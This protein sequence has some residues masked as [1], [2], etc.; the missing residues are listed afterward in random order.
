MTVQI[1]LWT[2]RVLT[3]GL[4]V[5]TIM[6]MLRTGYW[7]VRMSDF[8]R[9]QLASIAAGALVVLVALGASTGWRRES[10]IVGAVLLAVLVWQ[11][12]RIAPYTPV[13]P[14]S[15]PAAERTDLRLLISNLD[16]RNSARAE[17]A[18]MINRIE[19]DVLLLI[20]IEDDW[21]QALRDVRSQYAEHVEEIRGDGLGI[22]LWSKL[23]LAN[24]EV[25]FLVS[26]RRPSIVADISLEDGRTVRFVGI[27]PTPPGLPVDGDDDRYD[28]RIRDAELMKVGHETADDPDRSWIVAGDFNDVAWSHTTTLFGEVSGLLDPRIGRKLLNTYHSGYKLLRYPLDHIF[29]SPGFR[30]A[31]LERVKAPGSDHFAVLAELELRREEARARPENDG[32]VEE[33]SKELI[34]EGAEDADDRGE[35]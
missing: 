35:R 13:W 20:E 25:R 21:K 33:A 3:V 10:W 19:P 14:Q 30:I 7:L 28:S 1:I 24:A 8:P 4:A 17:T 32:P 11:L 27:H 34:K 26:E 18:A 23:P 16:K 5:L 15:V 12:R 22:A 9:M 29:V 6:P 2:L 31:T